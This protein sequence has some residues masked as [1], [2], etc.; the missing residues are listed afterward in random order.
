MRTWYV[1]WDGRYSGIVQAFTE[2]G[3]KTHAL[4]YYGVPLLEC[5]VSTTFRGRTV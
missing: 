2:S 3:A 5:L 4:D 1:Y